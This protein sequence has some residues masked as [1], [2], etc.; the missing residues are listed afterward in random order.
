MLPS[1]R[2]NRFR[3]IL[4]GSECVHPASI[5]D[6]M[7]ARMAESLGFELGMFAGS[8]ASATVLGAPDIVVLTLSEFA[9]QVRRIARASDLSFL[10][11]ADHGYGN[12]LNVMRTVEELETAGT[13]GLTIEDTVLPKSYGDEGEGL[14]S[15]GEL[16]GKLKAALEARQDPSLVIVGRTGALRFSGIEEAEE[17]VKRMED[18]GVD[19]IFLTTI[20]HKEQVEAVHKVTS[21]PLIIGGTSPDFAD[22]QYL[23]SVGVRVA[24]QGHQP[25]YASAK[26]AYD[27][28]KHLRD[29]G[30]PADLSQVVASTE[31][32]DMSQARGDYARWQKEYLS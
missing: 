30:S 29:G 8:I 4:T 7:S 6:P 23:A 12:A 1:E 16:I 22:L 2:R 3:Q 19:A 14:I 20:S 24:L 15:M 5:Y 21:L 32:L 28:L 26:A 25:F 11:D 18:V 17:R 31:L 10:V 13:S 9:E 27:V